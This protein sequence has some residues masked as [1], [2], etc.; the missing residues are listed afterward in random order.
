VLGTLTSIAAR[1][2]W[3]R[4]QAYFHRSPWV[5]KGVDGALSNPFAHAVMQV[6]AI[7][8]Q[9]PWTVEV[10]RY[11]AGDIEVD[12]TAALRLTFPDGLRSII[13]VS[14]CAEEFVAGDITVTGNGGRAFHQYPTDRLQLPGEPS[15]TQRPG[16]PGLLANLLAHRADPLDVPLLVPVERTRSFTALLSAIIAAP[17]HP[18]DPRRVSVRTDLPA[19][20]HVI[21]GINAA[22]EAAAD[23]LALFSEVHAGLA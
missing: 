2:A 21:D 8:R 12:D 5:G 7:A 3:F 16:R 20:R 4:D 17:V 6:L 10:E 22:I 19:P 9:A 11:R 15:P 1:G 13:A 23:D 14:L 18:I